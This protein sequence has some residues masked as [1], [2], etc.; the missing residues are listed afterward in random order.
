MNTKLIDMTG[1]LLSAMNQL[2]G[3]STQAQKDPSSHNGFNSKIPNS[4]QNRRK[5][6]RPNRFLPSYFF[7]IFFL[8]CVKSLPSQSYNSLLI[9][10]LTPTN[11]QNNCLWVL[12][13]KSKSKTQKIAQKL[14]TS[15][16]IYKKSKNWIE[17]EKELKK[18]R[19]GED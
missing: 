4:P 8:H 5:Q 1:P 11:R 6:K 17:R 10:D 3:H 18:N 9:L 16:A 7:W 14:K 13:L 12:C 2:R 15:P 19:N